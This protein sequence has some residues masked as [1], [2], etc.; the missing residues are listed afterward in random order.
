[1]LNELCPNA[2]NQAIWSREGFQRI[3]LHLTERGILAIVLIISVHKNKNSLGVFKTSSGCSL[4][5]SP[6]SF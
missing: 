2:W 6:D 5:T 4:T 1:M 3:F